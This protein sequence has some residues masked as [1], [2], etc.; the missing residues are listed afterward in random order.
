MFIQL[1]ADLSEKKFH[2]SSVYDCTILV[3]FFWLCTS[4]FE[5]DHFG[6]N[7]VEDM[8]KSGEYVQRYFIYILFCCKYFDALRSRSMNVWNKFYEWEFLMHLTTTSNWD[9]YRSIY[10]FFVIVVNYRFVFS[11]FFDRFFWTFL[12]TLIKILVF[13]IWN[14]LI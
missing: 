1:Q 4:F 6:I 7:Y 10:I 2:W 9:M 11:V 14:M 5:G 8:L 13:W 3:F 12:T